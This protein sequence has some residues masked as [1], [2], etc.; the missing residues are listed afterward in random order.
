MM[1]FLPDTTAGKGCIGAPPSCRPDSLCLSGPRFLYGLWAKKYKKACQVDKSYNP[2]G[3]HHTD[4]KMREKVLSFE[5]IGTKDYFFALRWEIK[6][7]A[8][9][10][11]S[12]SVQE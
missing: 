5:I 4:K 12:G 9:R 8:S 2:L 11:I 7:F 1:S 3:F 6:H 10:K